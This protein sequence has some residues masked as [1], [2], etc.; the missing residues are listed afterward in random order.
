MRLLFDPQTG[1]HSLFKINTKIN[2]HKIYCRVGFVDL[3][4]ARVTWEEGVLILEIASVNPTSILD[5]S[6]GHFLYQ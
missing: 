5:M 6:V 1:S 4:Q 3:T 2:Y